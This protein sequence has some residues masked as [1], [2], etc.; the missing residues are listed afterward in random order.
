MASSATTDALA[1][2]REAYED[3][4]GDVSASL[5][6]LSLFANSTDGLKEIVRVTK[7]GGPGD[8]RYVRHPIAAQL[9]RDLTSEQRTWVKQVLERM[10]GS[11][12][13]V[14]RTPSSAPR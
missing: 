1:R 3:R 6:G 7:P 14:R 10:S 5:D 2:G 11:V 13:A 9:T 4:E 8:D 12:P